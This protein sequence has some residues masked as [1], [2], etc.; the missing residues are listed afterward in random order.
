[1]EYDQQLFGDFELF[2]VFA[3]LGDITPTFSRNNCSELFGVFVAAFFI[4]NIFTLF[5]ATSLHFT[6]FS[7]P[8]C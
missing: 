4:G 2:R 8:F 3:L 7:Q 5:A 1:M 6:L